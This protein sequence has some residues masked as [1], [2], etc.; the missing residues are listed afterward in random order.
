MIKR[1]QSFKNHGEE[2][3]R[4]NSPC[5]CPKVGV[6]LV[7]LR[8]RKSIVAEAERVRRKVIQNEFGEVGRSHIISCFQESGFYFQF[9]GKLLE[10]FKHECDKTIQACLSRMDCRMVTEGSAEV[11]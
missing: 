7:F 10:G 5:K 2:R 8:D 1:N 4:K 3:V 11:L 6:D 9:K